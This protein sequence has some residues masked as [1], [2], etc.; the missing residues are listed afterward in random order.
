MLLQV[1]YQCAG[2]LEKNR[3]TVYEE[4]INI[5]KASQVRQPQPPPITS[6]PHLT[7]SP[8]SPQFQLVA[9]LF[10]DKDDVSTAKSSRVNVRA[11][12]SAPKAPNKEHRKTV[13]LQVSAPTSCRVGRRQATDARVCAS[14]VPQLS[15]SP[16]GHAQRHDAALRP[17]Y[18]T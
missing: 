12:K 16:H 1:E 11:A 6:R 7:P 10:H 9:D 2:F 18:Q 15:S 4:Q 13:G 3:D 14:T 8:L 17:L 5:L